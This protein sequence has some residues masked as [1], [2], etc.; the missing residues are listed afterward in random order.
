MH[1]YRWRKPTCKSLH[2]C[3]LQAWVMWLNV[4]IIVKPFASHLAT[5][6]DIICLATCDTKDITISLVPWLSPRPFFVG[7]R[8]EP[9]NEATSQSS[10][11][12]QRLMSEIPNT[13]FLYILSVDFQI[14]F[15]VFFFCC[16]FCISHVY[17]SL[18][19]SCKCDQSLRLWCH[20]ATVCY[21]LASDQGLSL[22]FM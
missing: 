2:C 17:K 16:F 11:L 4:W 15:S 21:I 3:K 5:M 7:V 22:K 6:L 13:Q 12:H 1:I 8:G 10:Y 14:F 20:K 19:I 9:R 18:E